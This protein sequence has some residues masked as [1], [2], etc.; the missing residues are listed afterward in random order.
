MKIKFLKN[1]FDR[2]YQQKWTSEV[3][4]IRSRRNES[5]FPVYELNDYSGDQIDGYFYQQELQHVDIDPD[6]VFKIEKILSKRGRGKKKEVKV[7]WLGWPKK[8]DQWIKATSVE[9]NK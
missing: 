4:T 6:T 2:E 3:F 9:V 1:I 8:Y 5:G 7:R